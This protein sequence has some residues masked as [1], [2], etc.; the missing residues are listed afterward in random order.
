MNFSKLLMASAL[1][2]GLASCEDDDDVLATKDWNVTM[3]TASEVPAPTGRTET[4]RATFKLL[5]DNSLQY[6]LAVDS[7][8]AGDSL[9]M[10]HLHAGAQ[11]VAGP[12]ILPLTM[13]FTGDS[14]S[15]TITGVRQTLADSLRN[16]TGGIYV[17]VHST[18][19][20]TGLVRGQ[21]Q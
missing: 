17:N 11:G 10:A 2:V 13:T 21:V 18:Q 4:G 16:G 5:G 8:A 3:N 20:P 1:L 15:G 12:V 14:A 19:V 6:T 9:T 7:V